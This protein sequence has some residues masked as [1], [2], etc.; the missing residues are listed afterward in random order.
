[1][2]ECFAQ[3]DA[4]T[5]K[6]SS[7][8]EGPLACIEI[9]LHLKPG[10]NIYSQHLSD[11]GPIP[12][13]ILFLNKDDFLPHGGTTEYG[14]P[15]TYYNQIY[16]I[17]VTSY[18]DYVRYVQKLTP[19]RYPLVIK[20]VVTFMICNAHACVPGAQNFEVTIKQ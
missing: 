11:E 19:T 20:G 12:T 17:E 1:M 2:P 18:S 7:R 3:H 9:D 5:W 6:F 8:N 13:R 10:W 14:V 15:M 4:I 16:G